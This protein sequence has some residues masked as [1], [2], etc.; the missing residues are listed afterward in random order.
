MMVCSAQ[1]IS[2]MLGGNSIFEEITFEVNEQERVGI[3]GRN[4][5]GKTTLFQLLAGIENVDTGNIHY[6]KGTKIGYLAQVPEYPG[7]SVKSVLKLAFKHLEEMAERMRILESRMAN[8]DGSDRLMKEY[9]QLLDE[10][11]RKGGYEIESGIQNVANGLGIQDLLL[12]SFDQLSG[13]EKTKVSLGLL[14]L[15]EPEM[16]LLDE[17]TNHLDVEAVDG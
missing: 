1:S 9:G 15:Q 10:F 16:L 11:T 6:K 7:Y 5:S 13:G 3:V 8:G 12:A 14:L 17:P 4:G 2:K